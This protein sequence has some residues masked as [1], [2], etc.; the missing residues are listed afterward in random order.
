[1]IYFFAELLISALQNI[2][3]FI[4]KHNYNLGCMIHRNIGFLPEYIGMVV[5]RKYNKI[6]WKQSMTALLVK[7]NNNE[8]IEITL[9]KSP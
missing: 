2:R 5:A 1:M 9:F 8:T 6:L 4:G 3:H 7:N